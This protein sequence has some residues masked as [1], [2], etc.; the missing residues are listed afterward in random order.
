MQNF[1]IIFLANGAQ[2]GYQAA[3]QM[4]SIM[5]KPQHTWTPEEYRF[6]VNTQVPA[7]PSKFS[8]NSS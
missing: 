4:E 6:I 7:A 1:P 3:R 8:K 5:A 2:L